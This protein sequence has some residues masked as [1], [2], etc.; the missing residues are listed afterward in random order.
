MEKK[1]YFE[2][3]STFR[4][5]LPGPAH[6]RTCLLPDL[7]T[8][9]T[10]ADQP[11]PTG[12][13]AAM[14]RSETGLQAALLT[15]D[16]E[17]QRAG[18]IHSSSAAAPGAAGEKWW[19]HELSC[20]SLASSD[21]G[22]T[23]QPWLPDEVSLHCMLCARPFHFWRWT[24]HCRDCGG[25]YC[26]SC[27]SHRVE[28]RHA[29]SYRDAFRRSAHPLSH[30]R[31]A[32]GPNGPLHVTALRLCDTC[33]FSPSHPEHF[34][35]V[36]PCACP[37]CSRPRSLGQLI[38]LAKA[39]LWDLI[40]F[41]FCCPGWVCIA[42]ACA[43]STDSH[44][45]Q[46]LTSAKHLRKPPRTQPSYLKPQDA[47]PQPPDARPLPVRYSAPPRN[48][49]SKS[50]GFQMVHDLKAVHELPEIGSPTTP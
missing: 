37:R 41:P 32:P 36:A 15:G 1:R 44:L 23:T 42:R 31:Q 45:N 2:T 24:H 17:A 16:L 4:T 18:G 30:V 10:T 8:F 34:G 49:P 43:A 21:G 9:I 47:T 12:R 33:A 40:C 28:V 50:G 27:S 46:Q 6:F 48:V 22:Y 19:A 25:L 35:C 11:A 20:S 14:I 39:A 29:T 5:C 38:Y 26:A 13:R 3:C 7:P